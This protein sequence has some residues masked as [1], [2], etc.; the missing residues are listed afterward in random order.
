[1][2]PQFGKSN[3][4]TPMGSQCIQ[5]EGYPESYVTHLSTHLRAM[6]HRPCNAV[7]GCF[8]ARKLQC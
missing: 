2:C 5:S 7:A 3:P 4:E 6:T 8:V 1:M